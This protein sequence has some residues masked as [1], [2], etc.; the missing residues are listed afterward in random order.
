MKASL[1][2]VV[3]SRLTSSFRPPPL[4]FR[5]HL[6]LAPARSKISTYALPSSLRG[7]A[8]PR[9]SSSK[10]NQ[11]RSRRGVHIAVFAPCGARAE[12]RT[13]T[14]CAGRGRVENQEPDGSRDGR[15]LRRREEGLGL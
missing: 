1:S 9:P 7:V 12:V 11:L 15:S 8:R 4:S 2:R 13:R 10:V 14:G 6:T 5:F 3:P